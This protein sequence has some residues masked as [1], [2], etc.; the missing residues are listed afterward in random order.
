MANELNLLVNARFNDKSLQESADK[1]F[2]NLKLGNLQ[3]KLDTIGFKEVGKKMESEMT[4]AGQELLKITQNFVDGM[5]RK[6]TTVTFG[7]LDKKTGIFQNQGTEIKSITEDYSKMNSAIIQTVKSQN[8]LG[9]TITTTT[10]SLK[11]TKEV[12]TEFTTSQGSLVKTTET[13]NLSSGNL[14]NKLTEINKDTTKQVQATNNLSNS[15]N[16]AT[17]STNNLVNAQQ[18]AKNTSNNLANSQNQLAN[19]A[20][21]VGQSF[22]DVITKVAKFYLA[23]LPIR[24]VQNTITETIQTVKDFDKAF[25]EMAKVTDL[26]GDSLD[27]YTKKLGDLGT[28]VGRTRTTM[29]EL[30]T[31]FLKA[32]YSEEDSAQLARYG[33]LLQ[34]TADEELEASEA[35]SILVSALKAFNLQADGSMRVLD[36]INIVSADFAVSSSDISRGL[37]QAGAS[38]ATYGNSLEQ[39]IGLI[40]AGENFLPVT[41]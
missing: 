12:V 36:D 27:A 3:K 11:G 33:A 30:S 4:S 22:T 15:N 40:T 8:T 23:S 19:S 38:M 2:Q 41:D 31:G 34:N 18:N 1:S 39:T 26:S 35:T 7:T 10:N 28:E 32:G 13:F 9:H 25:T 6:L 5:N 14:I 37:T 16:T 29:T 17:N 20:K 24:M 21:S